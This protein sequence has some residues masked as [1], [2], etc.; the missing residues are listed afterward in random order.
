VPP[1]VPD[2]EDWENRECGKVGE[3]R[4]LVGAGQNADSRLR[5]GEIMVDKEDCAPMNEQSVATE[6]PELLG[7]VVW[8]DWVVPLSGLRLRSS[9]LVAG[10]LPRFGLLH[11]PRVVAVTA[12]AVKHG[13]RCFKMN[14]LAQIIPSD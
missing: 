5:A 2:A 12:R 11:Q 1:Q 13:Q 3:Y 14:D 6:F 9:F 8:S 10:A 4:F 7:W